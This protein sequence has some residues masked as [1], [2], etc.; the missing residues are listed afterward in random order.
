MPNS[1]IHS[2]E[3][4]LT[5][6]NFN[7]TLQAVKLVAGYDATTRRYK[8]LSLSL[9]LGHTLKKCA[10]IFRSEGI[11]EDDERK[12]KNGKTFE[13]LHDSEWADRVS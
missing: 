6:S 13:E 12:Q 4:C 8:N 3:D 2:I 9:N 5:P 11:I 10:Q 7:E 1:K